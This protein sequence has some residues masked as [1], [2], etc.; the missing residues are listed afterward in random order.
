MKRTL[1]TLAVLLLLAAAARAAEPLLEYRFDDPADYGR[2]TG[3]A[4]AKYNGKVNEAPG[5]S[6]RQVGVVDVPGTGRKYDAGT[7][8]SVD[9]KGAAR[10]VA[11]PECDQL[12]GERIVKNGGLTVA[13]WLCPTSWRWD[14]ILADDAFEVA[15]Q[16][17][18]NELRIEGHTQS[19]GTPYL[20][21]KKDLLVR[22]EWHFWTITL[23]DGS[24]ARIYRDGID[25][26]RNTQWFWNS[27]K[28]LGGPVDGDKPLLIGQAESDAVETKY[29]V[30]RVQ[31]FTGAMT[32]EEVA[33]LFKGQLVAEP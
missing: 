13:F 11:V 24:S 8:L 17:T 14:R 22:D 19:K 16:N 7:V 31:V 32:A 21:P 33:A 20:W 1:S 9:T 23:R 4:G 18:E 25:V 3:S 28:D 12:D 6:F 2:N 27:A 29:M 15:F 26:S 5:V 10:A 30:D